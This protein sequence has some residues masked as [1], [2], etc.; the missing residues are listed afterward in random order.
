MADDPWRWWWSRMKI[1]RRDAWARWRRWRRTTTNDN[2]TQQRH[3]KKPPSPDFLKRVYSINQNPLPPPSLPPPPGTW[4]YPSVATIN[5]GGGSFFFK[6]SFFIQP[7]REATTLHLHLYPHHTVAPQHIAIVMAYGTCNRGYNTNI[8]SYLEYIVGIGVVGICWIKKDSWNKFLIS[9]EW[10][11][12]FSFISFTTLVNLY[13]W[14][15]TIYF[16][17]FDIEVS[18]QK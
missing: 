3:K 8:L 11:I 12:F 17:V 4:N 18:F 2:T 6:F 13:R 14:R 9:M 7:R 15:F 16:K 1:R 10:K 5:R